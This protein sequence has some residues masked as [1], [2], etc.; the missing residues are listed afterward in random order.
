MAKE[1]DRKNP[2]TLKYK[3]FIKGDEQ[4]ISIPLEIYSPKER[5][6]IVNKLLKDKFGVNNE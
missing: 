3:A 1:E 5:K 6:K 4:E 2:L